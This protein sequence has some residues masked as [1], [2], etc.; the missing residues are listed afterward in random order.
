[1][2][3]GPPYHRF[4]D[5]IAPAADRFGILSSLMDELDLGFSV[6]NISG[7]RHFLLSPRPLSPAGQ[8]SRGPPPVVLVAHYDRVAD[9]PGANDNSAAVFLLLETAMKLRD[10]KV[11]GWRI[12]FTDKEELGPGEGI[13]DQGSY[14][15]ALGL[16]DTELRDGRFYIFDACGTG[17]TLIISTTA[18]HLM[19]NEEGPGTGRTRLLVQQLRDTALAAARDL[20]MDRVL[21][22]RTPF[23]DD[24]GFLRAGIAAQTITVL[25]SQEAARFAALL[26]K[27]PDLAEVLINRDLPYDRN[28]TYI[29]GTWRCLNSPGDSRLRLTPEHFKRVVRFALAL[30]KG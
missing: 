16:R 18:D 24:A 3:E 25:P 1:M 23:S 5:F 7:L 19:K 11:P 29:P 8:I 28:R 13:A 12:I 22:L 6:L 2:Q 20:L 4:R 26:R 9:S 27:Q 21:L 10:G 15:L 30:C 14:S 17:D